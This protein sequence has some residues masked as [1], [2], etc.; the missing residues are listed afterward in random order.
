MRKNRLRWKKE[1][2]LS[3]LLHSVEFYEYWLSLAKLLGIKNSPVFN[4]LM[5]YV[6]AAEVRNDFRTQRKKTVC[7]SPSTS[8]QIS[9]FG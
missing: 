3:S 9:G 7:C 1:K 5:K 6:K 4:A 8:P 2:N